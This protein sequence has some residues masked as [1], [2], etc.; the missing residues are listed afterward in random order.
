MNRTERKMV[1]ALIEGYEDR[2]ATAQER[3]DAAQAEAHDAQAS[4]AVQ[5]LIA[6]VRRAS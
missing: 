6:R 5:A 1:R 4:N 3:L 2:L